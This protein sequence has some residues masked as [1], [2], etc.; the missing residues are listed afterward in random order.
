[1][2]SLLSHAAIVWLSDFCSAGA[3]LGCC[4]IL[5][6]C[7]VVTRFCRRREIRADELSTGCQPTVTILKPL[8][9][10]ER[11]LFERLAVFC[12]QRHPN[13]IQI[14]F[15]V[16]NVNDAAIDVVKRLLA[17]FPT[18]NCELVVDTRNHGANRKISNLA[19][20]ATRSQND[21]LV[22]ADSDIAVDNDYLPQLVAALHPPRVGAVTCP[23]HGT[24]S[25]GV[26][27][28]LAALSINTHFLP[29]AVSAFVL[30]LTRPCFGATIA[31]R[32]EV[33]TRVG[34]FQAFA[35][36]LADDFALGEAI[37]GA[38]YEVAVTPFSVAHVC[39]QR[40]AR[41]FL[42]QRLRVAR[43]IKAIDPIGY[44]GT[45]ITH[46]LPLALI[47]TVLGN[48]N[49]LLLV[50]VALT[51]RIGLCVIVERAF[52]LSR[53]PYLMLPCHDVIAFAIFIISLFG[54]TVIWRG[55]S[56]R[57]KASGTLIEDEDGGLP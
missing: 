16:Q 48:P 43:T 32:K 33:L 6:T 50:A 9:G 22:I 25:G 7:F 31:L 45:I 36:S 34:G 47:A 38:G 28:Q 21:I 18:K 23:Y 56:Y 40:D 24:A 3:T 12:Q 10:D 41:E 39:L 52:G 20:I 51:C 15:G 2:S 26:W 17:A 54:K 57:V 46:P 11:G 35:D 8:H 5:I 29:D 30:G 14:L 42:Q 27:S 13:Q 55:F 53:Q 4:Y 37:R 1:M 44:L 19:N 49:A